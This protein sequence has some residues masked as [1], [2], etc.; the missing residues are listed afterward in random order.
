[1][2]KKKGKF[3]LD[4]WPLATVNE[5]IPLIRYH[6]LITCIV[7]GLDLGRRAFLFPLTPEFTT[8][9]HNSY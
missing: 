7:V 4:M 9:T 6:Y 5:S 2:K 3:G 1:M 8:S